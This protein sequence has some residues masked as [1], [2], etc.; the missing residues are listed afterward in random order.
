[1]WGLPGMLV[2]KHPVRSYRTI[3]PLPQKGIA[4]RRSLIELSGGWIRLGL[5][6]KFGTLL[7]ER[8]ILDRQ[9]AIPSEAVYF[10][11]HFPCP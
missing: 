3:S 4:D 9:S 11:L 6:Q 5:C 7:D 10:L 8:S 2:A 1:M